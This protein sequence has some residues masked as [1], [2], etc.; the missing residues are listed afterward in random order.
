[1]VARC[2]GLIEL[3]DEKVHCL[4][5]AHRL[6]RVRFPAPDHRCRTAPLGGVGDPCVL[7]LRTEMTEIDWIIDGAPDADD[8]AV[9]DRVIQTTAIRAQQAG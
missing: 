8:R 5:P 2:P 9:L 7:A 6:K 1:M 3:L 4:G